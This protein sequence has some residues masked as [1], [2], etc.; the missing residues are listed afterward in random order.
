[1]TP[2]W[3]R[4]VPR[5]LSGVERPGPRPPNATAQ[6]VTG[7]LWSEPGRSLDQTQTRLTRVSRS[8]S[9]SKNQK[10]APLSR[11]IGSRRACR[12]E[13]FRAEEARLQLEVRQ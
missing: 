7:Q 6:D 11:R 12:S 10:I 8:R 4:F 1:M 3:V 9:R 2:V 13:G 5:G